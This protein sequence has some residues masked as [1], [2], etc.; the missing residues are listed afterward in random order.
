MERGPAPGPPR[1]ARGI[2]AASW[3]A[4]LAAGEVTQEERDRAFDRRTE[5]VKRGLP[6]PIVS[7]HVAPES[8]TYVKG[9][10]GF[11][12]CVERKEIEVLTPRRS[13]ASG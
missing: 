3:D 6:Y 2:L 12:L 13:T 11:T 8:F 9:E 4:A 7:A 5:E 1:R 10:N